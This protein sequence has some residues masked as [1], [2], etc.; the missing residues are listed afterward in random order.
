MFLYLPAIFQAILFVLSLELFAFYSGLFWLFLALFLT[1]SIVGFRAV[2][3]NWSFWYLI[4]LFLLS[5]WA[6]IHLIDQSIDKHVFIFLSAVV[7][8]FLLLGIYRNKENANDETARGLIS[9]TLMASIFLFF[10]ASYGIYLNFKIPSWLLMLFYFINTSI[11]SYQYFT[12]IEQRRKI[13]V[14]IYSLVIGFAILELGWIVNFWPFGYLTTG[15]V[16]LIF[17]YILWDLAQN[18]FLGKLSKKK[19]FINLVFFIIM[20]AVVLYSSRW[21]PEM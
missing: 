14:L 7:Y 12:T 21:L 1:I 9:M 3:K 6:I 17:Y 8:Y 10:S 18:Y 5:V 20:S 16:L 11:V 4:V 2:V 19:V 15:F 13:T